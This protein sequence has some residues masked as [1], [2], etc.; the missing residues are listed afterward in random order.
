MHNPEWVLKCADAEDTEAHDLE[1]KLSSTR[2][3][4]NKTNPPEGEDSIVPRKRNM[5]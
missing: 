2:G 3:A 1:S 4:L 5:P